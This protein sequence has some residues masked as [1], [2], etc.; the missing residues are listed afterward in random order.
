MLVYIEQYQ[1][2]PAALAREKQI[3]K[4]NRKWKLHLIEKM[5]P[6]WNDL[7]NW[8]LE[9]AELPLSVL[10]RKGSTWNDV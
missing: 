7:Y 2:M 3:K 4:W 6:E 1:D 9:G 8:L 10:T 5:N